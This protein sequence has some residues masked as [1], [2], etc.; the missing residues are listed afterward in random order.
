MS[1]HQKKIQRGEINRGR[2]GIITLTGF[3]VR[4]GEEGGEQYME[5]A[6]GSYYLINGTIIKVNEQHS[7]LPALLVMVKG[8]KPGYDERP[9]RYFKYLY[10]QLIVEKALA[11]GNEK[12]LFFFVYSRC[13]RP[14][15]RKEEVSSTSARRN[16]SPH[17]TRRRRVTYLSYK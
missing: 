3:S 7:I 1:S 2:R 8:P 11:A 5:E 10:W 9:D 4:L 16:P 6:R 12:N 17:R 13:M 15:P 14:N